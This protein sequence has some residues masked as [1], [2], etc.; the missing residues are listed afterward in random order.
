VWFAYP[1]D[2][3]QNGAPDGVAL[4]Q[5]GVVIQFLSYEGVMTAVGG[6]AA[7]MTSVNIGVSESNTS[8]SNGYS[9][10]IIGTGTH[11]S[12]YTWTGPVTNSYGLLNIGQVIPSSGGGDVDGIPVSW[13][14]RYSI[15]VLER[16]AA[17]NPDGDP[18][19]NFEEFVADTDP[20]NNA[21]YFVYKVTNMT[22]RGTLQL[23]VGPPTT[24]SRIY[25]AFWC[26]N[27][28]LQGW[29]P[30]NFNVP[31]D[32]NGLS[33]YLTVTNDAA[34]RFYRTGVKVP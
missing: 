8:T 26:T 30:L 33:F 12:A 22:G 27:L 1:V 32:I 34:G 17:N 3:I 24:N 16:L 5:S 29:I 11:Y 28:I 6:P 21:S 23:L 14:D 31:G 2:G 13:W 18:D 9:L 15:P 7:G 10:Q 19:S 20:T 25:D 4:V